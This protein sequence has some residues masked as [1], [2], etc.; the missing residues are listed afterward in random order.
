MPRKRLIRD[1]LAAVA[2]IHFRTSVV[3]IRKRDD[4]ERGS[5]PN[6]C[7]ELYRF[8]QVCASSFPI[9]LQP[10]CVPP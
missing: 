5:I 2:L 4:P 10:A 7:S 9:S 3:R 1:L 6:V 8:S